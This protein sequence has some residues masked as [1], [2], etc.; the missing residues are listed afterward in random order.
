MNNKTEFTAKDSAVHFR[1]HKGCTDRS[2]ETRRERLGG[3][4]DDKLRKILVRAATIR[5]FKDDKDPEK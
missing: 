5:V 2:F 3:V 1:S 4:E